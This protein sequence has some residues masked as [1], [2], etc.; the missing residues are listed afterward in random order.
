MA[1]HVSGRDG[2]G[3][4]CM[5]Q[6]SCSWKQTRARSVGVWLIKSAEVWGLKKK[7]RWENKVL[8]CKSCLLALMCCIMLHG[9]LWAVLL[10]TI[11]S[12]CTLLNTCSGV[13]PIAQQG[14]LH[15]SSDHWRAIAYYS[16]YLIALQLQRFAAKLCGDRL[17]VW[18]SVSSWV[19]ACL[20]FLANIR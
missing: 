8:C 17:R 13:F 11:L 7:K 12:N 14:F 19:A 18:S 10:N 20:H 2:P 3:R 15:I 5:G 1:S 6:R 4:P 16:H 9:A